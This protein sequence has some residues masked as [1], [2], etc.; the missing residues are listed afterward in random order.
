MFG[1][2]DDHN[3]V[4]G[5][6]TLE[7]PEERPEL[8][9]SG[10]VEPDAEVTGRVSAPATTKRPDLNRRGTASGVVPRWPA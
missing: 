8:H 2:I 6:I 7:S 9:R 4:D 5:A 1:N 10:S 3:D